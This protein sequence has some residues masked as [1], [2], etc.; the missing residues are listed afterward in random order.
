MLIE[1]DCK[2][3]IPRKTSLTVVSLPSDIPSMYTRV[4]S[5]VKITIVQV[6]VLAHKC[7]VLHVIKKSKYVLMSTT[8]CLEMCEHSLRETAHFDDMSE[9]YDKLEKFIVK[10]FTP[11]D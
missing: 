5:M 1:S 9:I 7:A 11:I 10:E 2:I 4:Y 8:P 3:L 6:L